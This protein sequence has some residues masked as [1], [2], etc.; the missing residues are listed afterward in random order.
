MNNYYRI[1]EE[2]TEDGVLLFEPSAGLNINDQFLCLP[3]EI[4]EIDPKSL[5]E[6]LNS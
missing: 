4:T 1:E 2:L 6:Y 3:R 5:G